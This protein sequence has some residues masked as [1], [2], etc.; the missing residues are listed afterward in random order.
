M[1]LKISKPQQLEVE[2]SPTTRSLC[3]PLTPLFQPPVQPNYVDCGVYVIHFARV[4]F[5]GPGEV[6][7]KIWV[8]SMQDDL[9]QSLLRELTSLKASQDD[10]NLR[11]GIWDPTFDSAQFRKEIRGILTGGVMQDQWG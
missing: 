8:S 4:F 10:T 7:E 3:T 2:V 9:R 1:A 11:N 6:A 5:R